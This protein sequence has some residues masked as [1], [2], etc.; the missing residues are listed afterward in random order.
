LNPTR[1]ARVRLGLVAP[2]WV[3]DASEAHAPLRPSSCPLRASPRKRASFGLVARF[4]E[5]CS[6]SRA[7]RPGDAFRPTSALRTNPLS[8]IPVPRVLPTQEPSDLHRRP[9]SYRGLR[10]VLTP[11]GVQTRDSLPSEDERAFTEGLGARRWEQGRG[12]ARFTTRKPLGDPT[13]TRGDCSSLSRARVRA[14]PGCLCRLPRPALRSVTDRQPAPEA[15]KAV[16]TRF[17]VKGERASPTRDTFHRREPHARR[18]RAEART[19]PTLPP[20]DA[21]RSRDVD[22]SASEAPLVPSSE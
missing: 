12:I 9:L 21:E 17:L 19:Q 4:Q 18:A 6:R 2:P 11:R 15:A 20:P 3:G 13:E 8:S 22:R 16:S 7:S 14:H 1:L 5:R 10:L